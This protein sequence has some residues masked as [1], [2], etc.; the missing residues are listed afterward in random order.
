M[1]TFTKDKPIYC[2]IRQKTGFT[3]SFYL[4]DLSWISGIHS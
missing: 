3:E 2:V 4:V 1:K